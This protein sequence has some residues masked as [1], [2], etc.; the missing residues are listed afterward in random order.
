[1][2]KKKNGRQGE[3]GGRPEV[4]LTDEQVI[5]VGALAASLNTDQIADYFGI[6]RATFYRIMERQPEVMRRYQEGK[7]KTIQNVGNALIQK[8]LKGDTSS[9][10]FYLKTQ[11]GWKETQ[12][13]EHKH[14]LPPLSEAWK[15]D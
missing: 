4:V 10:V 1:M 6:N 5:E 8:A 2:G 15:D 13:I 12:Q 3:G 11:A 7:S 9:M 14:E